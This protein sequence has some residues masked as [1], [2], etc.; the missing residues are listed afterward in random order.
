MVSGAGCLSG[1][2][3]GRA[4]AWRVELTPQVLQLLCCC[5]SRRAPEPA[6]A[7]EAMSI[8][9]HAWKCHPSCLFLIMFKV[10]IKTRK[11]KKKTMF[12]V[13][14]FVFVNFDFPC[15]YL[16]TFLHPRLP[17]VCCQKIL[18]KTSF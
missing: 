13:E 2:S 16:M 9:L 3:E 4:D 1:C 14:Q 6:T 5:R 12:I 8:L 15:K 10:A 17:A 11:K 18:I 7:K